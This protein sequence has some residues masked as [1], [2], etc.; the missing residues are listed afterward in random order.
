MRSS[1]GIPTGAFYGFIK[2]LKKAIESYHIT[3]III[4]NDHQESKRKT[5]HPSYKSKRDITPT[6]LTIQ[7]EM[8]YTFCEKEHI[9]VI[10]FKGYEADDI[11]YHITKYAS[12]H[13]KGKAYILSSDKDLHRLLLQPETYIIDLN[14]DKLLDQ[15][16]L[17]ETYGK[18]I[19][20]E[21]IALF[22]ALCGDASDNVAGVK[23]IG[24]KTAKKIIEIYPSIEAAYTDQFANAKLSK[25]VTN[26]L[27]EQK[28]AAYDSYSLINPLP[29]DEVDFSS[30]FTFQENKNRYE[31]T[32]GNEVIS[33]YECHSLIT[34]KS[35]TE[36]GEED[37]PYAKDLYR[38]I[39]ATTI[40]DIE[41]IKKEIEA[42]NV[43][44]IDTETD[45]GDPMKA[46]MIGFSLCMHEK[47]AWYIP[48]IE[49]G[50]PHALK[51]EMLSILT[52]I[53]EKNKQVVMHN[54]LFD[55]H[56]IQKTIGDVPK[57]I[58]DTMIAA[59]VLREQKIGLKDLSARVL[60]QKMQT[61]SDI[62][63]EG[64]H[65]TFDEVH[66]DVAASYAATDAR[67]TLLLF[68]HYQEL[69][70]K[71]QYESYV[72]L[73]EEVE[74]PVISALHHIENAGI[75]CN[76]EILFAQ[77]ETYKKNMQTVKRDINEITASH[78]IDLNPASYKQT[79]F[80][81][82]QILKIPATQKCKT[83]Q[84]TLSSLA[85]EYKIID[86]ILRYRSTQS[87]ITHFTTGL[88]KYIR[89]DGKIYTHY[90][91][92]ITATGRITT[93]NPNLQNI[94]RNNE[95]VFIRNAFHAAPGN[96]LGSFDYSQIELRIVAYLA[97]DTVLLDLFHS[98]EDIH[99]L[100][101]TVIFEKSREQITKEERQIGKK[102]NFSIIYGQS[103]F[104]LSRELHISGSQ[105]KT[106]IE[107]FKSHYPRIFAWMEEIK[108]EAKKVGY[109]K[110]VYGLKRYIPELQDKNKNMV[111]A[112]E[113][114]AVNTIVQGTAAEIMKKSMTAVHHYLQQTKK[115]KIVM[116]LHDEIVIEFSEKDKEEIEK[117]IHFIMESVVNWNITLSVKSKINSMWQ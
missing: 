91:Q 5:L 53:I 9:P 33:T 47:K 90:Q 64:N 25:R 56:V 30:F 51:T 11:L 26:I 73:F 72:Q 55:L 8:L 76:K 98:N 29:M 115:G 28:T 70:K 21:R 100:T 106:Y 85:A 96:L 74:M 109:V 22:Y 87:N 97:Q 13:Q 117:N 78:G 48:I 112:G 18:E 102:I 60:K 94:P 110:T 89:P 57:K 14:K 63:R 44:A 40:E 32:A 4:C 69:L 27:I 45:S 6:E 59:H 12:Q 61:F 42:Y 52:L 101:A 3:D 34:K 107:R 10:S 15:R 38:S 108:E 99:L 95:E 20:E 81:L 71:P 54:A 113:R 23:G 24:E 1:K 62:L 39:S 104:A 83:D 58:W 37:I 79:A 19:S 75:L 68:F 92:F 36:T 84:K 82:F 103:A 77:E 16:W 50:I 67:Q 46:N 49:K 105:A 88:L 111:K 2:T 7:K 35:Q 31:L 66:L 93:I 17:K 41:M 116:Q 43:I 114:I 80:F 86:L 65:K